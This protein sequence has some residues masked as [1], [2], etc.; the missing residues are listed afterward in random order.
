VFKKFEK[1]N[2]FQIMCAGTPAIRPSRGGAM[3]TK[4]IVERFQLSL[5]LCVIAIRNV[6]EMSG[7]DIAFLP[8]S[9]MRGKSLID[10]IFSVSYSPDKEWSWAHVQPVLFVIV[11]EMLVDWLKHAFITKFNHVR[12]SVYGRYM[13]VLAR[14]VLIAGSV[15]GAQRSKRRGVSA[16]LNEETM[17]LFGGLAETRR[18]CCSTSRRSLR[19]AWASRPSRSRASSCEWRRKRSGC[20]L[21]RRTTQQT[22]CPAIGR[23][24]L[25]SGRD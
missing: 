25:L 8:K 14:D 15:S 10:S 17:H 5:M 19:V 20:L 4:D 2:L 23:G 7:S 6:I 9:F 22:R 24:R 16:A 18:R 1:E 3:L 12:A 11:S 13:D 21:S